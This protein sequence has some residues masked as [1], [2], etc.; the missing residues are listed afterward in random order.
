MNNYF[1]KTVTISLF[2]LGCFSAFSQTTVAV[3]NDNPQP[4]NE[5]F[6]NH[7]IVS[8]T[9][10]E[11]GFEAK[12]KT[13]VISYL[14]KEN[15]GEDIDI[16]DISDIDILLICN[17]LR[18][19]YVI[20]FILYPNENEQ[21]VSVSLINVNTFSI[22]KTMI[23]TC[24]NFENSADVK[25]TTDEIAAQFLFGTKQEQ[26]TE[27]TQLQTVPVPEI[28][29]PLIKTPIK[30]TPVKEKEQAITPP[31][32]NLEK[33]V[34]VSNKNVLS[35]E[36]I[37]YIIPLK[38]LVLHFNTLR[39]DFTSTAKQWELQ[40]NP[41][42][43]K[44]ND[45]YA[46]LSRI[47]KEL[48]Y[49]QNSK[50]EKKNLKAQL[51]SQEKVYKQSFDNLQKAGFD[52]VK[53]LKELYKTEAKVTQQQFK[54]SVPKIVPNLPPSTIT[55]QSSVSFSDKKVDLLTLNYL[56]PTNNLVLWFQ[57]TEHSFYKII[58]SH[59]QSIKKMMAD[60]KVLEQQLEPLQLK[61]SDYQRD[62]KV[63]KKEISGTKKEIGRIEKERN[64]LSKQ[65]I[66]D[67]KELSAQMNDYHKE[68]QKA[69]SEKMKNVIETIETSFKNISNKY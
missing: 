17:Q 38:D 46:T 23:F 4:E 55:L 57:V 18:D 39:T 53:Q 50:T 12:D 62:P 3:Y 40:L 67:S 68:L 49:G 45:D 64:E 13:S 25:E 66:K 30:E 44:M 2:L 21:N 29:E 47:D 22:D 27:L 15:Q 10:E 41:L 56:K 61:L 37:D 8:F 32:E 31:K 51:K 1:F 58:E 34:A 59:N 16:G 42:I 33:E 60:D 20:T 28:N 63:N 9:H 6:A 5:M 48:T 35:I 26:D 69:F 11:F 65:V 14:I 7:L 54:E 43:K 36:L 52:I 19:D 24:S